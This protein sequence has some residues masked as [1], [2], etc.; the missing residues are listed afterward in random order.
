MTPTQSFCVNDKT[1][2]E[3]VA[4]DLNSLHVVITHL[5]SSVKLRMLNPHCYLRG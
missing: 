5:D 1:L 3:A 4:N 2:K